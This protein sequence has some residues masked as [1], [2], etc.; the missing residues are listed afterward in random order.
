PSAISADGSIVV[1]N[2]YRSTGFYWTWDTGTVPIAGNGVVAGISA[3]G[4]TIVGLANDVTGAQNAAIWQWGTD[5]VVIGS[6]TPDSLPCGD[7]Y[8]LL[9]SAYGVNGDG[10]VIVGLGWDGCSHAHGFRWDAAS[11]MTDLGSKVATRSSRAN[12]ISAD[13]SAIVGWSDQA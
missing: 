9:S 8:P 10:S 1:G 12:A 2:Y 6:F 3:D 4:T 11:G 5:W 7:I 13:G